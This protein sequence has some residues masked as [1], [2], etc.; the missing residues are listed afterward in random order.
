ML[1][2]TFKWY[3]FSSFLPHLA[4]SRWILYSLRIIIKLWQCW[5]MSDMIFYHKFSSALSKSCLFWGI[6]FAL[7]SYLFLSW[8]WISIANVCSSVYVCMCV[9]VIASVSLNVCMSFMCKVNEVEEELWLIW[10]ACGPLCLF[11]CMAI[12]WSYILTKIFNCWIITW[13][14]VLVWLGSYSYC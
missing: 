12:F 1:Q 2:W 10:F 7:V 9:H 4:C 6:L 13:M 14:T 5:S 3:S 11:A 8:L